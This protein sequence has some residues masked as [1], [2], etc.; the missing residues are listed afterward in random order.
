MVEGGKRTDGLGETVDG[1]V[2]CEERCLGWGALEDD[3]R[4]CDLTL[5]GRCRGREGEE[6]EGQ[7]GGGGEGEGVHF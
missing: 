4:P 2:L 5:L 1:E 3:L 7:S 6:G